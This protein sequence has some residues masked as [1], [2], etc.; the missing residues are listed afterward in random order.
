MT[1]SAGLY[2]LQGTGP[3]DCDPTLLSSYRPELQGIL[4]N[5]IMLTNF[6]AIL[7]SI[8]WMYGAPCL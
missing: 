6:Q 3:A 7:C 4:A 1:N 8:V 2:R 5:M